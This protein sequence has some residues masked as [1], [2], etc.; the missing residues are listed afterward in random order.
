MSK[1]GLKLHGFGKYSD[2]LRKMCFRATILHTQV[3][4]IRSAFRQPNCCIKS[5]V[6]YPKN[7]VPIPAP[8]AN[9]ALAFARCRLK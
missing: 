7:N 1:D 9:K 2:R 5:E 4:C 8:A 6:T 3:T